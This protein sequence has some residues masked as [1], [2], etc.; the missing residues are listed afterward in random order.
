MRARIRSLPALNTVTIALPDSSGTLDHDVKPAAMSQSKHEVRAS[1]LGVL[2]EE[3]EQLQL[4][5]TL[6]VLQRSAPCLQHLHQRV[7]LFD[8]ADHGRGP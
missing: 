3:P 7:D 1:A 2:Q 5:R 8:R 4:N 6:V